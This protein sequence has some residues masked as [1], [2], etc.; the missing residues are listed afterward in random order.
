MIVLRTKTI[1]GVLFCTLA[2]L[3]TLRAQPPAAAPPSRTADAK[4]TPDLPVPAAGD[5]LFAP[6]ATSNTPQTVQQ[7]FIDYAIV[8]VGPRALLTPAIPAALRMAFPPSTFPRDWRDGG[9]AYGKN[10]ADALAVSA[11]TETGKFVVSA[12]LHEDFR[13]RPSTSA[14]PVRRTLHAFA[15]TLVDKSDS[16]HNRVALANFAGAASGGF[17]GELYLP[18]GFNDLSH[19]ETRTAIA[20]GGLIAKNILREF[21]PDL[22]RATEQHHIPFPHIPIPEWWT[23]R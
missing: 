10:Y 20:F 13:Y 7:K 19:A 23:R 1:P 3:V 5:P 21:A 9:G 6:V 15:F 2:S 16:G 12:L 8:T 4:V 18:R 22:L 11:S 14:N 17:I